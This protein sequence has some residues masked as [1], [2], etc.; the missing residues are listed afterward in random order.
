[1]MPKSTATMRPCVVDEQ[2]A[3]MH[4][5]VEKAV[6]HGM[7]QEGLHQPRAE[8][9]HVVAGGRKRRR[10]RR[11]GC[12]RSIRASAR[13]ARSASNRPSAR[14]SPRRLA[15]FSAISEMA[16][17][18]MRRSISMATDFASV[19]T[20]AT[21]RRRRDGAMEALDHARGEDIAVEVAAG[22]AARCRAAAP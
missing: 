16:A 20:T 8:R 5:G 12:R 1:M 13:A 6:A 19:S 17:A 11:S 14:G 21:G 9:L 22:S 4:V 2:I 7:A 3:L 15:M 18:S 10:G